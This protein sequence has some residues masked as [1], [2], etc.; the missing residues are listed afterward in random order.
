MKRVR[1]LARSLFEVGREEE[2][3]HFL[4]QSSWPTL[5]KQPGRPGG[6]SNF[7]PLMKCTS[8]TIAIISNRRHVTFS[9]LPLCTKFPKWAS[10]TT[11]G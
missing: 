6:G 11:L 7:G 8:T 10:V 5:P 3:M 4:R 1:P 2:K 9:P